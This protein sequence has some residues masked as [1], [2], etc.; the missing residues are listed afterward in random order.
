MPVATLGRSRGAGR[1][2]IS[3]L[4][5][6]YRVLLDRDLELDGVVRERLEGDPAPVVGLLDG[7]GLRLMEALRWRVKDLDVERQNVTVRD[8]KGGKDRSWHVVSHRET[9]NQEI[10]MSIR[11]S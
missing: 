8:S 1:Q 5:F 9:P 6:L 11:L 7:S 10:G 3:A 2:A 4:L